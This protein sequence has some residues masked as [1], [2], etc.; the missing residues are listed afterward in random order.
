[1]PRI[2]GIISAEDTGLRLRGKA[3]LKESKSTVKARRKTAG[4]IAMLAVGLLAPQIAQAQETLYLSS[5]SGT[6]TG[7]ASVGSDS[8]L[9]AAFITGAGA[10]GYALNSVQLA[11]TDASGSPGGFAVMIY[12]EANNPLAGL[13]GSS[14]GSLT[15]SSSPSTAGVYSYTPSSSLALLSQTTY[16]IVVTSS[17]TVANGAYNWNESA[18]PPG[19]NTWGVGINGIIR[20]NNGSSGW[21]PTPYLGIAQFAI[22]A[23][24]APEPGVLGLFALGGL[25]VAFQRRK[26]RS[27]E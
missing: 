5:L 2:P 13:P 16:F 8:W 14:L 17:T 4:F 22:Y 1:L 25:L 12:S 23:T 20:S 15:G 10:G 18:F 27:V 19:V 26:A 9:A 11:M 3:V 21:S 7:S 24:P 6:S